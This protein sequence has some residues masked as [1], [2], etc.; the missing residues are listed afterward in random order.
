MFGGVKLQSGLNEHANFQSF[1]FAFMT[2]FRMS[3]G[4]SWN[5]IMYD[6]ARKESIT[7]DC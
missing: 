1:S 6:A 4:E 7:Y 5:L 2:L 3:T